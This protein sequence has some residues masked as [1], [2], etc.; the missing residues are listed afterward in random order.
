[1]TSGKYHPSGFRGKAVS[2]CGWTTKDEPLS[3][4]G[5]YFTDENQSQSIA[6]LI[7]INPSQLSIITLVNFSA[8]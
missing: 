4:R 2:K 6:L 8:S 3:G 1:M 7:Y 5:Y